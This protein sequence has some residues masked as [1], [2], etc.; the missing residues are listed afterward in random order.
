MSS[1]SYDDRYREIQIQKYKQLLSFLK[2]Q[3]YNF[4]PSRVVD[5]GAGTGLSL[6]FFHEQHWIGIDI[7]REMVK[8]CPSH[9]R[10]DVIVSDLRHLPLRKRSISFF[11]SFT[12]YQNLEE[13]EEGVHELLAILK[14][15]Y[16]GILSVLVG[17][18]SS[19][20]LSISPLI[21]SI[22]NRII[23]S[24]AD[25]PDFFFDEFFVE[26]EDYAFFFTSSAREDNRKS[27]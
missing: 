10:S 14:E 22:R 8:Q 7:S 4:V 19:T 18:L 1:S 11:I 24:F 27:S 9:S 21:S 15:K 25:S 2:N 12:A 23:S 17:H 16:I 26:P 20:N 6:P 13:P 3:N 5:L